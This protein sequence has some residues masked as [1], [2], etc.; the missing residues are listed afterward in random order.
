[1]TRL[2]FTRCLLKL[3][4]SP[5]I[6]RVNFIVF[7]CTSLC[8]CTSAYTLLNNSWTIKSRTIGLYWRVRARDILFAWIIC[9]H[10]HTHLYTHEINHILT[11]TSH[12]LITETRSGTYRRQN[13]NAR[14]RHSARF[15]LRIVRVLENKTAT[16]KEIKIVIITII[17]FVFVAKHLKKKEREYNTPGRIDEIKFRELKI[18]R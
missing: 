17:L 15:I 11:H 2:F 6:S 8:D 13:R 18:R 5:E 1:M 16:L 14:V 10:T 3:K 12:T 4:G 9:V 7:E